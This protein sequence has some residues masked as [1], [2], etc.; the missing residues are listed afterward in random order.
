VPLVT[1]SYRNIVNYSP[2]LRN[3]MIVTESLTRG[4]KFVFNTS[5]VRARISLVRKLQALTLWGAQASQIAHLI[6]DYTH[7]IVTR[8]KKPGAGGAGAGGGIGGASASTPVSAAPTPT[9]TVPKAGAA[10]KGPGRK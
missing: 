6:R 3:L 9:S 2:S 10:I 1:Y 7:I 4:T 5:Q 8:Q